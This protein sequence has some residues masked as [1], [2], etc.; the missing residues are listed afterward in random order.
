MIPNQTGVENGSLGSM[1]FLGFNGFKI[2][3][4]IWGINVVNKKDAY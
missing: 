2:L 1:G 3:K 4:M